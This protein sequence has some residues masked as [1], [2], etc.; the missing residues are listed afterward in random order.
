MLGCRVFKATIGG[1]QRHSASSPLKLQTRGLRAREK[2]YR[3][4]SGKVT[5]WNGTRSQDALCLLPWE[6]AGG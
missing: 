2:R 4:G 6:A 3:N 5:G 1:V